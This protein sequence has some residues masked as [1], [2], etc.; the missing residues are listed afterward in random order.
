MEWFQGASFFTLFL[1][2]LEKELS[3]EEDLELL[4][5]LSSESSDSS[6]ND[7]SDEEVP[8]NNLLEFSPNSEEDDEEIEQD[9]WLIFRKYSTSYFRMQ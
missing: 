3:L 4:E 9:S 8:G 7:S 2:C 5:R 1:E 6:K